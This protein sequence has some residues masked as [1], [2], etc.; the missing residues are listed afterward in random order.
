MSEQSI[1][2]CL[3][4]IIDISNLNLFCNTAQRKWSTKL[5]DFNTVAKQEQCRWGFYS[6]KSANSFSESFLRKKDVLTMSYKF[7]A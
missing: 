7:V 6:L 4:Y 5:Y 1:C 3:P 2:N